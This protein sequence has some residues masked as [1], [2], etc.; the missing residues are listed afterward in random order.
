LLL[1]L[2]WL[3]SPVVYFVARD[4]AESFKPGLHTT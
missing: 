4:S 2:H 1:L 3:A